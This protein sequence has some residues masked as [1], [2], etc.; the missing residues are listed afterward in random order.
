MVAGGS[1]LL[2]MVLNKKKIIV[3]GAGFGGLRAALDLGRAIKKLGLTDRYEVDLIDQNAFHTY[4][5]T[6]YEIAT[7]DENLATQL[8]LK[9]IV[10]IDV[11]KSIG[12]LPI[13]FIQAKVQEIDVAG[14]DIHFESGTRI[15][16][17]CLVLAL[18]SQTNYFNIPG[19]ADHAYTFKTVYDALKLRQRLIQEVEDP[20]C[21]TLRIV[22]G[23]AGSTGVELAAEIK[24]AV[25]HMSRVASGQCDVEVSIV[26]G[27]ATILA[28]F[29]ERIIQSAQK[30]FELLGI[31][32]INAERISGV[33]EDEI[34]FQSGN[35]IPY[36]VLIWTGG[37]A[38][39]SLMSSLRMEKDPTGKRPIMTDELT[40]LP[41]GEDLRFYGPIYGIG[42]A[43]CFM[44]PKTG[45]PVPGVAR[46]AI[47]QGQIVA[48]NI[49]EQIK[50]TE[51]MTE[52]PR[53]RKYV[54]R[55]YPYIIPVGGKYAIAR[56]GSIVFSGISAWFVKGLVEG[57]YLFSILPFFS[58]LKLW[59][60]GLW[61]F[62]RNDRLG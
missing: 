30:R 29:G 60:K 23:G 10:T 15:Q 54:P 24:L 18:G 42:D 40:C 59:A 7:T 37:V 26:D 57:N 51:K 16:F 39:N 62:L 14:G 22:V 27:G 20:S 47:V 4:A 44:D 48:H 28:P 2:N 45:R 50:V 38:P 3:L 12:W 8:D 43:V 11:R 32:T 46:A 58:A 53:L 41:E 36:D 55:Q 25:S 56:F 13:D 17:D 1:I 19:L 61:I 31:K 21:R 49:I 34:S 33:T 6:L 5:P 52:T 9:R 35:K